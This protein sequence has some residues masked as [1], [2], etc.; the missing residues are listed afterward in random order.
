MS[1]IEVTPMGPGQFGVRVSEG[2]EATSHRVTVPESFLDE[3]GLSGADHEE[4]VR[5][6]FAF[7]LER[8]PATSIMDDFALPVIADH[9]PEYP[10]E[11]PRRLA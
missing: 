8:E 2:H 5:Q 7:L 3:L 6:S 11:L 9:F 10:Q 4:V 1:E